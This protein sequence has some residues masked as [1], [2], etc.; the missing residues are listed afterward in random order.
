MGLEGPA[1]Q[2]P[3]YHRGEGAA[4]L[5]ASAEPGPRGRGREAARQPLRARAALA[6]PGS[7]SR[8]SSAQELVIGGWL[9]E[10]ER[11]TGSARCSSATSTSRDSSAT[12][13]ASGT[14][15][16]AKERARLERLLAPLARERLAVRGQARAARRALCRAAPRGRDRVHGVD[17]RRGCCAIPRTRG[18]STIEAGARSCWRTRQ[19]RASR[20]SRRRRRRCSTA[21]RRRASLRP[22]RKAGARTRSRWRSRAA[23]CG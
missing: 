22:G 1:W 2:T 17:Q 19:A 13:A 7:R 21:P 18:W 5:E 20:R 6:P 10:K 4:L 11:A 14:G 9:P 12:P 8:T 3:R 23:R 16:D 15:W